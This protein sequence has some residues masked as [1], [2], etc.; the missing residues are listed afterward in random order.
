MEQENNTEKTV[1]DLEDIYSLRKCL[2]D[3][4]NKAEKYLCNWQRAEADFNNYKKR[5]EQERCDTAKFANL[6]LIMNLLPVLDDFERAFN[7]I[8]DKLSKLTWVDGINLILR[9]L[10]ATLEAQ[11]ISEIIALG[12]DFNPAVHEAV[13]QT[14]GEEGKITEELQKGYKLGDR[15]IRPA[16][17]M[18]GHGKQDKGK[19]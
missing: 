8:P 14:E 4:K 5:V 9:K 16:L 2:D 12:E 19:E 11:G 18:V 10:Q 17:V 15:L 13:G 6:T 1:E 3:E 7:T